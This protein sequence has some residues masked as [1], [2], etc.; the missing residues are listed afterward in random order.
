MDITRYE[1]AFIIRKSPNK[2]AHI[3]HD[4]S[5]QCCKKNSKDRYESIFEIKRLVDIESYRFN[6]N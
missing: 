3:F 4:I 2:N 5:D 1:T 6:S